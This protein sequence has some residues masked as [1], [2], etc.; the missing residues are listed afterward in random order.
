MTKEKS[1]RNKGKK[2]VFEFIFP[3]E[4]EKDTDR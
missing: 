3:I 4:H 1:G 2:G